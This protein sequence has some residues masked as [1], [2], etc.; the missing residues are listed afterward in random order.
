M[1]G[2]TIKAS[3]G[4]IRTVAGLAWQIV[5]TG[6]TAFIRWT[7][8]PS[9]RP[10]ATCGAWPIRTGKCNAERNVRRSAHAKRLTLA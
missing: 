2:T 6:G 3:E 10:N 5:L 9:S 1:D 8:G 7:A 4:Y